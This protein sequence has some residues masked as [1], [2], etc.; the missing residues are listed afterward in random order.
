MSEYKSFQ[1]K[2]VDDAI[3]LA[4]R[5]FSCSREELEIE[6]VSGG[7]SGIFGL[8]GVKKAQI[9]A[10]LRQAPKPKKTGVPGKGEQ[11]PDVSPKGGRES[12]KNKGGSKA[13]PKK[14]DK[15]SQKQ[16]EGRTKKT[17]PRAE[18]GKTAPKPPRQ[19]PPSSSVHT[20]ESVPGTTQEPVK[21]GRPKP[22]E[23][24]TP[25]KEDVR[26]ANKDI[27]TQAARE[28]IIT[29]TKMLLTNIADGCD[30]RVDMDRM[31]IEVVIEDEANSGLI[32]G[33]DGQTISAM[34]YLLN[35]I[36]SRKF[37]GINRIQLDAGDYREKQDEQLRKTALFLAQKAKSSHRTQSTRPLSSYHRRVVHMTLQEDREIMTRSKGDGP[38]KR[39]LVMARRKKNNQNGAHN[40]GH[41]GNARGPADQVEQTEK[42]A[43]NQAS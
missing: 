41:N 38:M 20:Q 2:Q 27:D 23:Q 32:I 36:V 17:S 42:T 24:T 33:R 15:P 6:I 29:S 5:H 18:R 31:P 39:V 1:G 13:G 43:E 19:E 28:H 26:P 21:N 10:R 34:Q 35:R 9:K 16:E 12:G 14:K 7:S 8:V 3:A 22:K 25:T 37:P 30:I 40:Q 4:C 11:A